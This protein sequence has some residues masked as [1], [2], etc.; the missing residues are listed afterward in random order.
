MAAAERFGVVRKSWL[1]WSVQAGFE[2]WSGGKGLAIT[3]FSV[4][5]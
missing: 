3:N 2:I 4:T 1:L 5:R